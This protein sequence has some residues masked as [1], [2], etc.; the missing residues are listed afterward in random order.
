MGNKFIRLAKN[1]AISHD[2]R[3]GSSRFPPKSILAFCDFE[4][5]NAHSLFLIADILKEFVAND[6]MC[7]SF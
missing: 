7:R 4:V 3:L 5:F 2:S 6:D 1:S